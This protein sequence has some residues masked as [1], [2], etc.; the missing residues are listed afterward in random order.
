MKSAWSVGISY[1]NQRYHHDARSAGASHPGRRITC[2]GGNRRD[3]RSHRRL[4]SYP[5]SR[6]GTPDSSQPRR[7]KR[8]PSSVSMPRLHPGRIYGRL[9]G[10]RTGTQFERTSQTGEDYALLTNTLLSDDLVEEGCRVR[11]NGPGQKVDRIADACQRRRKR[12]RRKLHWL[13]LWV[14]ERKKAETCT[15]K[16]ESAGCG[17]T[18][19][20]FSDET[21]RR[22]F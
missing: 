12:L 8:C 3:D 18:N 14:P 9:V 5:N 4:P 7:T 6:R 22:C 15:A 20:S 13:R 16:G 2:G 17:G 11:G 21:W 10:A 1:R 19:V